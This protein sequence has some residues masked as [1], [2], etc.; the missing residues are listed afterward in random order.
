MHSVNYYPGRSN[1]RE[2]PKTMNRAPTRE[3]RKEKY[4]GHG[5]TREKGYGASM[6]ELKSRSK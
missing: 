4:R 3:T 5:T 1:T 6:R 2:Y